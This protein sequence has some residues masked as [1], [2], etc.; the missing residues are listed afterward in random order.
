MFKGALAL[1]LRYVLLLGGSA[2][3]TAGIITGTGNGYFCFD[4]RL[5]ADAAANAAAMLL[6]GGVSVVAGIGWRAWAKRRG[7][8]T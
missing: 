1:V 4:S 8:L 2:L 5:V 7:G 6:G 3:A